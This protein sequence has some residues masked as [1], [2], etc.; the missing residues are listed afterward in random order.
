MALQP[1]FTFEQQN[2]CKEVLF[3][4]TTGVYS[5]PGNTGGYGAPNIASS[6]VT[7]AQLE[8]KKSTWDNPI[9]V[10]YTIATNVITNAVVVDQF[11][12]PRNVLSQISNTAFP[13]V[14]QSLDSVLLYDTSEQ[15]DLEVGTYY[16]I[17]N[18]SNGTTTYPVEKWVFFVCQFAS[19]VQEAG[20]K[21][22][23]KQLPTSK[24]EEILLAFE[25]LFLNVSLQN[26][27]SA[28]LQIDALTQ[29]CSECG[30]CS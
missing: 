10:D 8:I 12:N 21:Y 11:G 3:N 9:Y 13:F 1:N 15:E 24:F 25:M 7:F 28:E 20:I 2:D 16:V 17:Y 5:T 26:V 30:C 6:A 22:A 29:L 18:V 19:C 14:N 27:S 4:D 23:N